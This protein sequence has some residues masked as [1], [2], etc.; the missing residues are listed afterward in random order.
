MGEVAVNGPMSIMAADPAEDLLI[1]GSTSDSKENVEGIVNGVAG[2]N[3]RVKRRAKRPSKFLSKELNR[4]NSDSQV[5][6]PLR[7]LKN[8]RKSRNGFGRGLPKKGKFKGL[9]FA[10]MVGVHG[11]GKIG[12][13]ILIEF[14]S[15][16]VV[17]GSVWFA[18]HFQGIILV[19][20]FLN[21]IDFGLDI[22]F[23]D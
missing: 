5:V 16:L 1:D 21:I 3:E 13:R 19:F 18:Y 14:S 2:L 23:K 22:N 15:G 17:M 9:S 10:F 11:I 8:S 7:A 4:A 12:I 20:T 6:A